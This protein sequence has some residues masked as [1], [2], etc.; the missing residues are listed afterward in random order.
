MFS[1]YPNPPEPLA[2]PI[3]TSWQL[4]TM[5]ISTTKLSLVIGNPSF[6]GRPGKM[7]LLVCVYPPH[8]SNAEHTA[9][10]GRWGA[11]LMWGSKVLGSFCPGSATFLGRIQENFI[12]PFWPIYLEMQDALSTWFSMAFLLNMAKS[13]F[14]TG[15]AGALSRRRAATPG[16]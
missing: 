5:A 3:G 14:P 7:V 15:F 11:K 10:R 2:R 6:C 1:V 16:S 9:G 12:P 13:D 4:L 8:R